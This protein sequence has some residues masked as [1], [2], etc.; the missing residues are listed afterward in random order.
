MT[1]LAN[2][3][4]LTRSIRK[5]TVGELSTAKLNSGTKGA[6]YTLPLP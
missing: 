2:L 3:R 5:S 6:F 1:K 4:L